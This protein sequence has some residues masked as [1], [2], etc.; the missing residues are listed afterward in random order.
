[1]HLVHVRTL[2]G[3]GEQQRCFSDIDD[4]LYCLNK[5]AFQKNVVGQVINIG[6]DEEPVTVNQLA[7]ACANETGVNLDPIYHRDR[8]KEVKL[9]TCS[10]DKAREL[11]GYNTSSNLRQSVK[12]TAE[13]IRTRGT[14]KFQYHLPLEIINE[15]T[16]ETWKNKLI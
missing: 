4:C 8:P 10:S 12:K 7:E 2:R 1:M 16:P 11:L 5:L 13:Y 15:I 3:L 9:A 6:P 14:K